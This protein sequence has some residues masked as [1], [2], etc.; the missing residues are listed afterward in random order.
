[1]TPE[2]HATR[3]L[4]PIAAWLAGISIED[5]NHYAAFLSFSV[6]IAVGARQLW[7]SFKKRRK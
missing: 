2:E 1:M 6:G 4:F 5:L 7:L 3:G